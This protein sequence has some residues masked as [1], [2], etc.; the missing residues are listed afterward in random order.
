MK[1]S[2]YLLL[3]LVSF[4][5]CQK[6]KEVFDSSVLETRSDNITICHLDEYGV[7]H[8]IQINA[9]AL[10][11][12]LNHG[13]YLPDS[14]GDGFSALNAC[15]GTA[16]D[17]DDSNLNVY[18]GAEEICDGIDNDCDG[19]T[20]EGCLKIGDFHAGGYIFY[21]DGT[22]VHGLVAAT[23][24]LGPDAW[25]CF[26][27]VVPGADGLAVGTG[28][29]NTIAILAGCGGTAT[30]A[31]LCDNYS[32]GVYSDWFLPSRDELALMRSNLYVKGIGN[33]TLSGYWSSSTAVN[34]NDQGNYAWAHDFLY[35]AG[36]YGKWIG[37]KVRP[38]R[39]F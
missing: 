33:F 23:V 14:D 24:D 38:V 16:N 3:G 25:G 37:N 32:D 5:G 17:C 28:Y 29:Q 8:A 26:N 36:H 30:A 10:N 15:T 13:D 21:L 6:E 19:F 18:P 22:G 31:N 2:V 11:A 7:Y 20:D 34:Y 12:H 27:T 4:L 39:A 35:G 9:N 1:K